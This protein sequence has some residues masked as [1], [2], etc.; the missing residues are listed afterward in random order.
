MDCDV[1]WRLYG[2]P[3]VCLGIAVTTHKEFVVE[4]TNGKRDWVDPVVSVAETEM[5]IFVH[6]GIFQYVYEKASIKRWTVRAYSSDT[7]FQSI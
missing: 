5:E 1:F 3:S 2:I 6:N 4:F 7:T